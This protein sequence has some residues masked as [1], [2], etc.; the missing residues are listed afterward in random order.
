MLY[1]RTRL[2]FAKEDGEFWATLMGRAGG[3]P[4]D[5]K[6]VD[7]AKRRDRGHAKCRAARW[8]RKYGEGEAK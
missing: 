7:D 1:E 5:A 2:E 6:I 8:R 4:A 3:G